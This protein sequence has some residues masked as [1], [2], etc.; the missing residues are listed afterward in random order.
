M[1][2]MFAL[3]ETRRLLEVPDPA[4]LLA[5]LEAVRNRHRAVG[6]QT[7][8]PEPILD[9][10][11]I[12]RHGLDVVVALQGLR[13][14]GCGRGRTS[15]RPPATT[16][17]TKTTVRTRLDCPMTNPVPSTLRC[18]TSG[19]L[20]DGR[21]QTPGI[22]RFGPIAWQ[23]SRATPGCP[24]FKAALPWRIWTTVIPGCFQ[25][26]SPTL[27][28]GTYQDYPRLT[29]VSKGPADANPHVATVRLSVSIALHRRTNDAAVYY[30]HGY[31]PKAATVFGCGHG[32]A[33]L[34]FNPQSATEIRNQ[35]SG[36]PP[37]RSS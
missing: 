20:G 35:T 37:L 27:H 36:L 32:R 13:I 16:L 26:L 28:D 11:L 7:R 25:G 3:L 18:S 14:A 10:H 24:N 15:S 6:L 34:L 9:L 2:S 30:S 29:T 1:P 22:F 4:G 19:H 17:T 5:F 8:R 12:E 33:P 23:K 31:W 21:P